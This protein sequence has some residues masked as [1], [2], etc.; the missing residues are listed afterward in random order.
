[1]NK[2]EIEKQIPIAID[3]IDEFMKKKKF[4]KKDDK[5]DDKKLKGIPKEYKGYISNF[6]ASIIQSGL[7]STVA[8]FEANDSKSKSDKQVLMELIL[9]VVDIYNEKQLEWKNNSPFLHYILENNNKQTEEE[10]INAA[11]A[12]KL[13]MRVFKFTENSES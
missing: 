4:L 11:I 5:E 6:G 3:L 12:V 2:R 10:V 9:K 8:F 7:L 13:A 1:M